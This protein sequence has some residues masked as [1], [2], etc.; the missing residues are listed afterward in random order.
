VKKRVSFYRVSSW[1]FLVFVLFVTILCP[2]SVV[3]ADAD[4]G[5]ASTGPSYTPNWGADKSS[6]STKLSE[7]SGWFY[8]KI[9]PL[10]AAAGVGIGGLSYVFGGEK[11]KDR[12]IH[13]VMGGG[14]AAGSVA[15]IGMLFNMF[16]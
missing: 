12:V 9:L 3:F 6:V 4:S 5:T 13:G 15:L 2:V 11:Q 7:L 8:G 1:A 10:G 14:I 16:K